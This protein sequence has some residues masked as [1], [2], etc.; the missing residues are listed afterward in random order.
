M[1]FHVL[2]YMCVPTHSSDASH[3]PVSSNVYTLETT[4]YSLLAL[5]KVEVSFLSLMS[6]GHGAVYYYFNSLG[7]YRCAIYMSRHWQ[8]SRLSVQW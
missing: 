1:Y 8:L 7:A 3:W 4:A 6:L 5:V 2:T